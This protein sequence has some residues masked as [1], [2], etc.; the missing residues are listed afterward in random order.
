MLEALKA[1]G[2]KQ[3][4]SVFIDAVFPLRS[5]GC[6]GVGR[7][8]ITARSLA[9]EALIIRSCRE[10]KEEPAFELL[11]ELPRGVRAPDKR[12]ISCTPSIE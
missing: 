5:A 6:R 2:E 1:V 10:S 12:R 9:V 3:A 11:M 4:A 7:T 8:S